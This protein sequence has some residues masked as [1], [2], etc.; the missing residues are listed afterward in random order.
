MEP[1]VSRRAQ[2]PLRSR[3]DMQSKE[4]ESNPTE[5]INKAYEFADASGSLLAFGHR[6]NRASANRRRRSAKKRPLSSSRSPMQYLKATSPSKIM[7][8]CL[9]TRW[10]ANTKAYL[11][12]KI[13]TGQGDL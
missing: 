6:S 4:I 5:L 7:M 12:A 13:A 9:K 11:K 2:L 3:A 8:P 1:M 10:G